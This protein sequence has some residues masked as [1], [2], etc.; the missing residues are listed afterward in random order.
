V[1]QVDAGNTRSRRTWLSVHT[2]NYAIHSRVSKLVE[3]ILIL[4]YEISMRFLGIDA[5]RAVELD[6]VGRPKAVQLTVWRRVNNEQT[7]GS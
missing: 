5:M 7:Q 2:I 3:N 4:E 1:P 6:S